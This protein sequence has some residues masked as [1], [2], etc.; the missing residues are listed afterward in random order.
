MSD[1]EG[2][3]PRGYS[4]TSG[5][6]NWNYPQQG[7]Q[8]HPP[9]QQQQQQQY[10]Y[11]QDQYKWSYKDYDQMSPGKPPKKPKK[12]GAKVFL[13][14]IGVVLTL[15]LLGFAG[16]GIY[17]LSNA[18]LLDMEG[19]SSSPVAESEPV[20]SQPEAGSDTQGLNITDVPSGTGELLSVSGALST[21]QIN[22]K[23]SPSVVG[24]VTYQMSYG[25]TPA[26]EGSGIIMNENGYIVT[27]AHVISGA[28][29]I[30]VVLYDDTEYEATVVGSDTRTDLAVLKIE[31]TGLTAAEFGNS[32][33]MAAGDKVVAI[34]NPGGLEFAGSIT[35][36]IISAV[37]RQITSS[38]GYTMECI[39][40]DAAINP[41]NSGGALVN[42]Y[43][44]VIGINSSKIA[45]TDY[46]G[47]GF[48][49]P[50]N[51]AK[52]IID[53]LIDNGRVTGRAKL[54]ITIQGEITEMSAQ[55]YSI[56]TGILIAGVEKGSDMANKGVQANDIITKIDGIKINTVNDIY[57]ILEKHKPGDSVTVTLF[58]RPSN[59]PDQTFEVSVALFE[60]TG[61][62]VQTELPSAR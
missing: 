2:N 26:G 44:Q 4:G 18:G 19:S 3:D 22:I 35:Q 41:G 48:A 53:D 38:T 8:W 50:I 29:G 57:K 15:S 10:P 23:V 40:T 33:Q 21:K 14:I 62:A 12:N 43:G 37:N 5:Q 20:V 28:Q 11:A 59:G 45:A 46:E 16:F 6:N 56:P 58:R 13:A 49:I 61:A 17:S 39:Q 27:N 1:Y 60:D 52:P 31:A 9:V 55:L 47:I 51:T 42:E 36:G 30:K 54:G 7:S 25:W 32:E 34:G 24:V